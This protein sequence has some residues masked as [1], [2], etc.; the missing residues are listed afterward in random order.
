MDDFLHNLRSGK[1]KQ[2]DRTRREHTDY[3]KTSQQQRRSG[4]DRR[5]TDYY[6]KITSDHFMLIRDA[7][8]ALGENQRRITEA[9]VTRNNMMSRVV[10]A[11]DA[12]VAM[13]GREWGHTDLIPPKMDT[14]AFPDTVQTEPD[15]PNSSSSPED[16]SVFQS[17]DDD[18]PFE[19]NPVDDAEDILP[20]EMDA[21]EEAESASGILDVIAAMRVEGESWKKIAEY[22][23]AQQI[24]TLSGRGKWS[25]PAVKKLWEAGLS[26]TDSETEE[27]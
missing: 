18:M 21:I 27:S 25:G 16:N 26:D 13:L 11:L 5:R 3:N 9:M 19:A 2:Q 15:P 4:Y 8:N 20:M 1:L 23:D 17:F 10:T 6:A 14:P 12:L 24:P 7:M 22:F